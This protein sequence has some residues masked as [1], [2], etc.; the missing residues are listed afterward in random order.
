MAIL[1]AEAQ[2]K[3]KEELGDDLKFIDFHQMQIAN[4]KHVKEIEERNRKLIKLKLSA[5]ST[6][7]MLT[8][9]K[10][11]L[12]EAE[13]ESARF[14]KDKAAKLASLQKKQADIEKTEK[15]ISDINE[16]QRELKQLVQ[17]KKDMPEPLNFVKQRNDC[18]KEARENKD[19]KRK[20]EIAEFEFKKAR[21]ILRKADQMQ[22]LQQAEFGGYQW[23]RKLLGRKREQKDR[24]FFVKNVPK[25]TRE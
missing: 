8:K 13:L 21:A 5:G 25:K 11:N 19:W 16:K 22:V 3:Q 1:K 24:C 7:Q 9:L 23:G 2:I 20:I 10:K 18:V 17:N 12:S 14:K 4:K 15:A 6:T